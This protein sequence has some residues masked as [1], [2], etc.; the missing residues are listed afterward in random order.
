VTLGDGGLANDPFGHA[1]NLKSILGKV[2]RLDIDR[3][4]PGLAY[5]IPKD[6]P[7]VKKEGARGEIWA[8]GLRNIWRMAFD[9]RT[10][11]LW[12]ADVGQNLWEEIDLI[13]RGGNYGWNPREGL[14]PF[15]FKGVGPNKDMIEPIWEYHHDIGKSITGGHVYRGSRVKALEGLYL[16][17]D[18]VT[19]HVWGLRYDEEK[20]RVTAN[21]QIR[22]GGFPVYSFGE[23]DKGEV[24]LLTST[25]TGKGIF[26]F[27]PTGGK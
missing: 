16:Y 5:A 17:A 27:A 3:K 14:H 19:G 4:D 13:E 11:R 23:D 10:G 21:H 7:F 24:Y 15:G 25:A 12:A 20:K 18:Y 2:L 6:N 9:A 8:Y 26:W 22:Q 1:Q